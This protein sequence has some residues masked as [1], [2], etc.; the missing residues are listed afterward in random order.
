MKEVLTSKTTKN[1]RALAD[2]LLKMGADEVHISTQFKDRGNHKAGD[3]LMYAAMNGKLCMIP[4]Q[5]K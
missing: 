5:A 4:L 3:R 2:L 1:E